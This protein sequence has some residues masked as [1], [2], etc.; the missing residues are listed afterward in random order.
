MAGLKTSG[1]YQKA[2]KNQ[3][4]ALEE[5]THRSAYFWLH[6][7]GNRLKSAW[8]SSQD[9]PSMHS[10]H[11]GILL[12]P[13]L[14]GHCSPLKGSL[15]LSTRVCTLGENRASPDHNPASDQGRG[16]HHQLTPSCTQSEGSKSSFPVEITITGTHVLVHTWGQGQLGS[17]SSS[18]SSLYPSSNQGVHTRVGEKVNQQRNNSDPSPQ[19]LTTSLNR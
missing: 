4:S 16:S 9:H 18:P 2:V 5:C 3:G 1:V 14:L 19:V 13:L 8:G 6:H 12:Q 11:I 17:V 15:L 7:E 10:A